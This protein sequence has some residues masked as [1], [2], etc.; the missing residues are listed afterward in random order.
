MSAPKSVTEQA[1]SPVLLQQ[2]VNFRRRQRR[3][4]DHCAKLFARRATAQNPHIKRDID[5]ELALCQDRAKLREVLAKK[6]AVLAE[7]KK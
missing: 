4:E 5:F 2:E 7:S 3:L 1:A 6:A